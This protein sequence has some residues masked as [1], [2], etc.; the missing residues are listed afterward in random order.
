MGQRLREAAKTKRGG[1]PRVMSMGFAGSNAATL[2]K[3][4]EA[5]IYGIQA[6]I[7][8]IALDLEDGKMKDRYMDKA[9]KILAEAMR[10][11]APVAG[12]VVRRYAGG[13]MVAVYYPGNLRSSIKVL[14]HMKDKKNRYVGV[15]IMPVGQGMGTFGSG[16]DVFGFTRNDG[17]YARFLEFG[18]RKRPFIRPAVMESGNQVIGELNAFV[19]AVMKLHG[20]R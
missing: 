13:R 4:I 18:P 7:Q 5:A 2:N 8:E 6:E 16:G 1:G 14:S 3:A 17:W 15:Q 20:S 19:K 12:Q 9:S 11:R 10:R